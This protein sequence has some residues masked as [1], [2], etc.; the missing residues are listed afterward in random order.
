MSISGPTSSA[1]S[2]G[3]FG[4]V[5]LRNDVSGDLA[6]ENHAT[7]QATGGPGITLVTNMGNVDLVNYGVVTS[8][9]DR[10]LYGD[11]GKNNVASSPVVVSITN[12]GTVNANTAGIR[13]I[14]YQGLSEITNSGT[15][16]TTT[17][18]GVV[19]WSANGATKITNSG[20]V[21]AH[22][23]FALQAWSTSS[24]VTVVNSG[25]LNAYDDT[26]HTDIGT[27]PRRHSGLC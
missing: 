10:G 25:T 6:I 12:V 23:D 5:W 9:D 3:G 21:T 19:A 17:R 4:A 27:R 14:N 20:T 22:D 13:A 2:V 15:V 1:T 18:Q 8:T 11:G 24:D 26:S 7:M 16:T